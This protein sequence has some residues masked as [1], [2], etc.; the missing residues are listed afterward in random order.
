[1]K[2]WIVA[3]ISSLLVLPANA[4]QKTDPTKP[5]GVNTVNEK[6]KEINNPDRQNP[7]RVI[8]SRDVPPKREPRPHD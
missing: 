4:A 1:M 3:A 2:I 7:G 5:A 6:L 8:E